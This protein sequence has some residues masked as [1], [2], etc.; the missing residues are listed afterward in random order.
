MAIY[1]LSD[2]HGELELWR[3]IQKFLTKD[4]TLIFL[5]DAIDRGKEGITILKEMLLDDRVIYLLGNHE[6]NLLYALRNEDDREFLSGWFQDG[7]LSTWVEFSLL[8]FEEQNSLCK[9]ISRLPLHITYIN[10]NKKRID[11]S[12]S[13]Y[14]PEEKEDFE[15]TYSQKIEKYICN[16]KHLKEKWVDNKNIDYIIHGHTPTGCID[17]SANGQIYCYCDNHKIN[18]DT[19]ATFLGVAALLDLDTLAPIYFYKKKII[20]GDL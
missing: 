11:L 14:T 13:G 18:I 3:Q 2:I 10:K 8:P 9:E 12:H 6:T 7:G 4:D 19:G 20:K 1:A 17:S 16:R 15:Y 5:G